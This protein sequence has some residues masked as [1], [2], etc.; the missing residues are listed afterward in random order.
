M[1]IRLGTRSSQLA[2]CQAERV[3]RQLEGLGHEVVTVTI[4]TAGDLDR[5]SPFHQIGAPG[6]FVREIERALLDGQIDA[7]VHS[8]KDLPTAGPKGLVIAAVP[9]REDPAD[10]VVALAV[11]LDGATAI[12]LRAGARIG[13]S[14]ARRVA[15]LREL[16]P[17]L[18]LVPIR[19]NVPT[20]LR[21]LRDEPYDAIVLAAAGL[22]R[23]GLRDTSSSGEVVQIR[24]DP[25][26]FPPAPAQGAI[27]VQ[28][29]EHDA[30][31][32]AVREL[33]HPDV[34]REIDVER[35]LLARLEGGCQVA[36]GALCR[37]PTDGRIQLDA[38]F[39]INGQLRKA[40]LVGDDPVALVEATVE[41][42]LSDASPESTIERLP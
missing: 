22:D 24:L 19:G 38:A 13:T 11:S 23:L 42:L 17:D 25:V 36:C 30:I 41:Q 37:W 2:R 39:E 15:M 14:S 32:E 9:G 1:K 3:G 21:K 10:I 8:Y 34:R 12:P 33:D 6:V 40:S 35:H 4:E 5:N 16:R 29:R 31:G 18:D 26:T 20:R 28:V 7:A 27:A